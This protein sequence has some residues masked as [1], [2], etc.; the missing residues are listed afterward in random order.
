VKVWKPVRVAGIRLGKPTIDLS[1]TIGAEIKRLHAAGHVDS[2]YYDPYQLHSI[3]LDLAKAGIRMIELPQTAQRTE[4]DQ[5]LYDAIISR[6]LRHY[7]DPT[8]AEHVRNAVAIESP[9]GWRLAKEK[10]SLKIDACI[11]LSMAHFGAITTKGQGRYTVI[12]DPF[13]DIPR[14]E[15]AI[16][17]PIL[18]GADFIWCWPGTE[19]HQPGVTAANHHFKK[20]WDGDAYACAA[21]VEELESSGY[22]RQQAEIALVY[23]DTLSEDEYNDWRYSIRHPWTPPMSAE[24]SRGKELFQHIKE[25]IRRG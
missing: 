16:W 8:L 22:Y 18:R 4:A 5:S 25:Q 3:A 15:G 6:Q 13:N 2:V 23:K 21:C 12:P 14:P 19:K 17:I 20:H 11:G 10:T 9:R 1:E 24:D 7:G